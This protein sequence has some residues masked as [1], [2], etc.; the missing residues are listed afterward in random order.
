MSVRITMSVI[1]ILAGNLNQKLEHYY[2][3]GISLFIDVSVSSCICLQNGQ[4]ENS[5]GELYSSI[6]GEWCKINIYFVI[7]KKF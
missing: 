7:L 1:S 3:G 4:R 2:A 6:K 5:F